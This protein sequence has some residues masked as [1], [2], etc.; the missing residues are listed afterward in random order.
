MKKWSGL[1][2]VLLLASLVLGACKV[3]DFTATPEP[4]LTAEATKAPAAESTEAAAEPTKE[5]DMRL[6][7]EKGKMICTIY[8]GFFPE[9]TKEQ[10]ATLAVFPEITDKD[11]SRGPKDATLTILEY[12]D[13]QCPACLGFYTELEK[14]LAKYPDDV[15]LVFRNFPLISIHPNSK[16]A[17]QAAEAAGLQDKYW[18]MYEALFSKQADW[19]GLGAED[20]LSWLKTEAGTLGLNSEKFA[21]DLTSDVIV[22]KVNSEMDYAQNTIGLNSTPTIL[23]NGRPWSY[24]WSANTLGMVVDV[25]KYEKGH[26]ETECPP[27]VIDMSKSY[28]ATIKTEKGDIVIK[29]YDDEAPITVNSFVYLAEKGFFDG[30][31]FHRVLHDFVA[32]AGDPSGT[33]IS[34]SGYEFRDEIVSTLT[35]DEIGMVGMAN[36]GA[37]TNGSQF[38]I[39]YVPA[40]QLTGKYTIFGKVLEGMDVLQNLTERDPQNNPDAPAGDK[41]ISITIEAK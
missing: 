27:W 23:L 33:G 35:Y 6:F 8:K 12:S 37:N 29:L 9:L 21:S 19:S 13:F 11:W 10:A 5:V 1:I 32:Q 39:T 3:R 24:D 36:A 41:I 38:F 15:R 14:L 18:E 20:F 2:L 40:T 22:N 31:T 28:T 17:A 30:V 16:V 34:G 25:L 4:T 7:D 26:L